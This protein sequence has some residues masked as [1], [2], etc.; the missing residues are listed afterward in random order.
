MVLK[1][2]DWKLASPAKAWRDDFDTPASRFHISPGVCC[3][4]RFWL[5]YGECYWVYFQSVFEGRLRVFFCS[6]VIIW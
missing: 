6:F 5:C 3:D 4:S 1:S 2:G